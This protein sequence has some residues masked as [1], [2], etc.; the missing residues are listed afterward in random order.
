MSPRAGRLSGR[1]A[2][3]IGFDSRDYTTNVTNKQIAEVMADP[4]FPK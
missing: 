1:L 4:K 3:P 2:L